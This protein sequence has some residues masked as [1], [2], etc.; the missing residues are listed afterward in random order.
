LSQPEDAGGDAGTQSW[1]R[2]TMAAWELTPLVEM[3]KGE[4]VQV[5]YELEL[6]ARIPADRPAGDEQRQ[7]VVEALWDKLREIAES[8]PPALGE[9]ARI[10][11]EPF[12]AADRLRPET[13]FAP[14]VLLKARLFHASDYFAPVGEDDRRRMKTIEEQLSG[15][16]LRARSW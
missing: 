13:D 9:H 1:A 2:Q 14:E 6:Y 7:H 4:R 5:G 8:L 12:E 16:G 3:H 11:V 15:L 10:E